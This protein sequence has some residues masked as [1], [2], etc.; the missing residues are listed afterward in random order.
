[1]GPLRYG[2]QTSIVPIKGLK[3]SHLPRQ[4]PPGLVGDKEYI[5]RKKFEKGAF[6]LSKYRAIRNR[7][8]LKLNPVLY[9]LTLGL[10][11]FL[12]LAPWHDHTGASKAVLTL[13]RLT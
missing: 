10:C 3:T 9:V 12:V 11:H 1:M 2:V 4:S 5:F 8:D 13:P 7:L 6:F